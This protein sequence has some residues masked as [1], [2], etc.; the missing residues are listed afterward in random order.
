MAALEGGF[1]QVLWVAIASLFSTF[2]FSMVG[3]GGSQIMVPVLFWLGLDFTQGAIP[4]ALLIASITCFSSGAV[5]VR[6]KVMLPLKTAIPLAITVLVTA[7]LGAIAAIHISRNVEVGSQLLM[8]VFALGNMAVGFGVLRGRKKKALDKP[9]SRRLVLAVG[10][11]VCIG[12]GFFI[13]LI[14]RDG[15]PFVLAALVLVG[16]DA[17]ESAGTTAVIIS[18]GCLTA[19]LTHL[20]NAELTWPLVLAA[21]LAALVGSQA[22]SRLMTEKMEAKSIQILFAVVMFAIGVVILIQAF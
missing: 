19:F 13:G 20:T 6:N 15:G 2:V 16:F 22:G 10:I 18:A 14:G 12:V 9:P 3:A 8:I 4:L 11:T 21:S 7:P 17:K 5:Y 1:L